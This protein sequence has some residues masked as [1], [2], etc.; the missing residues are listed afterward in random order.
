MTI[1]IKPFIDNR[2][3]VGQ[4]LGSYTGGMTKFSAMLIKVGG[5]IIIAI[6]RIGVHVL[7]G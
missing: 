6:N 2:Y 3:Y 7:I 4:A 1:M 5:A